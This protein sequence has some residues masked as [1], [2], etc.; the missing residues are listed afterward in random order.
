[1]KKKWISVLATAVLTMGLLAGCGSSEETGA[2]EESSQDSEAAQ[3]GGAD[4]G[5]AAE[6]DSGGHQCATCR[7]TGSCKAYFSGAG[8]ES[9]SDRIPGLRSA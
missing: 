2:P 5:E 1:M 7:D 9:G 3:D 4:A 6:D 8:M